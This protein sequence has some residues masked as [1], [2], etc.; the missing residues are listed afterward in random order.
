MANSRTQTIVENLKAELNDLEQQRDSIASIL[1]RMTA[2]ASRD[3]ADVRQS[4]ADRNVNPPA[5]RINAKPILRRKAAPRGT[6]AAVRYELLP[7]H[8]GKGKAHLRAMAE[9]MPPAYA[10]VFRAIIDSKKPLTAF[11]LEAAS[12]RGKKTVESAVYQMR[13]AFRVIR[14]VKA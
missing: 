3:M 5:Q 9:A 7:R 8:A 2:P 13:R 6:R 1:D 10:E 11:E 4:Y 12:G 14:S